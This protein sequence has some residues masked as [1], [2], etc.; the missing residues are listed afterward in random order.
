MLFC[1]PLGVHILL[2]WP[3][4]RSKFILLPSFRSLLFFGTLFVPNLFCFYLVFKLLIIS[5]GP[6]KYALQFCTPILRQNQFCTPT[7]AK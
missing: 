3:S 2:L 1:G 5:L 4:F 7:K 6:R